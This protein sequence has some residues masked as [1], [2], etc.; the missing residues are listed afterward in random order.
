[1]CSSLRQYFESPEKK[2]ETLANLMGVRQP[3]ISRWVNGRVPAEKVLRV[4]EFT[5]I[6]PEQLRPDIYRVSPC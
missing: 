1:M 4:S 3:T 2:Q 5:D 6:P